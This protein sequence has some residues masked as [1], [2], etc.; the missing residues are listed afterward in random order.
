[1][2]YISIAIASIILQNTAQCSA[3]GLQVHINR[4]VSMTSIMVLTC[5]TDAGPSYDPHVH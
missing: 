1:M 5:A 2:Q 3:T 4:E